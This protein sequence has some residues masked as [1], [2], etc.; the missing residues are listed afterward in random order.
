MTP[1]DSTDE[2]GDGRLEVIRHP[3][4]VESG[5]SSTAGLGVGT[6]V[7]RDGKTVTVEQLWYTEH[8]GEADPVYV[9]PE[10]IP[11]LVAAL[12]RK[13]EEVIRDE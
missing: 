9:D 4:K 13:H 2:S 11:D 8:G 6:Y 5:V 3:E 1:Q 10:D 12:V 7:G